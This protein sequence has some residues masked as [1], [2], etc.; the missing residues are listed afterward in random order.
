[1]TNG[2]FDT[3]VIANDMFQRA[4]ASR[5][6]LGSALATVLFVAVLP[7]MYYQHPPDAAGEALTHDAR[8]H[9]SIPP[10]S[11]PAPAA[12]VYRFLRNIPT[13]VLWLLVDLWII[14]TFGLLVNSFR[15]KDVQRNSG[16]WTVFTGNFDQFT[17]HNYKPCCSTANGR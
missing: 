15:G 10:T 5:L 1:M 6:G 7:V 9:S 11:E 8:Q 2:N 14:P 16:W 12:A 3:Q 4:S 17:L 13:W